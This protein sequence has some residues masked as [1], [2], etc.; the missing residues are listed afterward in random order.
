MLSSF[1]AV[2]VAAAVAVA[3]VAA[4]AAG[5]AGPGAAAACRLF[6]ASLLRE[7]GVLH[8][9]LIGFSYKSHPS[10]RRWSRPKSQSFLRAKRR[11]VLRCV[12][13]P[14]VMLSAAYADASTTTTTSSGGSSKKKPTAAAAAAAEIQRCNTH[15]VKW[16]TTQFRRGVATYVPSTCAYVSSL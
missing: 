16:K 1:V 8:N 2:A 11:L 7:N 10:F 6:S 3:V 15:S 5:A 13:S 4:A 12:L 14:Y 9:S